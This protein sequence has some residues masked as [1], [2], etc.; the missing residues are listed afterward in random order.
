MLS[1]G[2]VLDIYD[3]A[4]G[5]HISDGALLK[6]YG[7][8]SVPT[9]DEIAKLPDRDFAL[10]I[11]TK[12]GEK[13]RKYPIHTP[14]ALALSLHYFGKVGHALPKD[15]RT[16]AAANIER[17]HLRFGAEAPEALS[18]LASAATVEGNGFN[19]A[20]DREGNKGFSTPGSNGHKKFALDKKL[21]DDRVVKAFPI[22]T[23]DDTQK[24]I[25]AFRKAAFDLPARERYET[26]L[27]LQTRLLE[28]GRPPDPGLSKVASFQPNPAFM[29][30]VAAR[31][32][33]LKDDESRQT[34]DT[35][36]KVA[37]AIP[38]VHRA[39][40]LEEFDRKTGLAWH[41]DR[42]I[43]NP[44]D[45]CFISKEAGAEAGEKTITKQALVRLIDSGKLSGM[46]KAS[47]LKEF[48][49]APLEI[50][51]SL[52]APTKQTIAGLIG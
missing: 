25:Q 24:S 45:S 38:P 48:K 18:K 41:W 28:F 1:P 49:E 44:W 22:D 39:M 17:A 43:R 9:A 46:F 6:K 11:F 34:L 7:E 47:T 13:I 12:T 15:A 19:A 10:V 4:E 33:M 52:P 21:A 3:D 8:I 16:I 2:H 29:T 42:R 23:L 36:S 5:R 50:F 40:A 30:H 37:G 51:A 14:E 27:R 32:D 35:F 31:K 26:A 20:E